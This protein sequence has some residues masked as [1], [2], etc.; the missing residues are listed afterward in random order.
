MNRI[1]L[2]SL[3]ASIAPSLAFSAGQPTWPAGAQD[4]NDPRVLAFYDGTCA[5]Y[6]DQNGLTGVARDAYLT[7][8]RTDMPEVYPVG[9]A[10]GGGGG[11]DE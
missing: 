4:T 10:Q 7:K 8:C 11:G 9:Y 5:H 2:I 1:L 6:A 3:A